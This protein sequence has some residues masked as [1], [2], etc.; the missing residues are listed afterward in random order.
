MP[1][2]NEQCN[3]FRCTSVPENVN[4]VR[5]CNIFTDDRHG[6][7]AR[8]FR[9]I[10]D[11]YFRLTINIQREMH[12]IFVVPHLIEFE[13]FISETGLVNHTEIDE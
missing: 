10:I 6:K 11:I 13:A 4:G 5:I 12:R 3:T 2:Q 8:V 7:V 9:S 1:T